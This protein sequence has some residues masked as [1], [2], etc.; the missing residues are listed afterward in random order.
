MHL[1]DYSEGTAM[2]RL[3]I[4]PSR[5]PKEHSK[6]K[7][8]H[9]KP[10]RWGRSLNDQCNAN[11]PQDIARRN[12]ITSNHLNG[13]DHWMSNAMPMFCMT[14]ICLT[15]E[16]CTSKMIQKRRQFPDWQYWCQELNHFKLPGRGRSLNEQCNTN[17]LQ[18]PYVL[19]S[20]E[21]HLA[22]LYCQ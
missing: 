11:V 13:G 6:E 15:P 19:Y 7:L 1:W 16:R 22:Q 4:Y 20:E 2:P 10:P 21:I 17:V 18:D 9:F 5:R 12:A 8:N 14:P 3:A